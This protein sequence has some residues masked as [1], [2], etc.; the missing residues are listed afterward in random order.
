MSSR[1]SQSP[2]P[3]AFAVFRYLDD[4]HDDGAA[5]WT[6]YYDIHCAVEDMLDVFDFYHFIMEEAEYA[7]LTQVTT[8][9]RLGSRMDGQDLNP[10]NANELGIVLKDPAVGLL[11]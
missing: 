7:H 1:Q 2:R 8:L 4:A 9:V 5:F 11:L 3:Q 10:V 6:H